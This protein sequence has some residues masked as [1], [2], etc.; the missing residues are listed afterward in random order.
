MLNSG[1]FQHVSQ[2]W[3][4]NSTHYI[5]NTSFYNNFVLLLKSESKSTKIGITQFL[6]FDF[7]V[8]AIQDFPVSFK[9]HHCSASM[10][11]LKT[12]VWAHFRIQDRITNW[13]FYQLSEHIFFIILNHF[14]LH[15]FFFEKILLSSLRGAWAFDELIRY[16][17]RTGRFNWG[18]IFLGGKQNTF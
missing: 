18:T 3:I 5:S 7:I 2:Y 9:F 10:V 13:T 1:A 4:N 14:F 17:R 11:T 6:L 15:F 8:S 12:D 16:Q